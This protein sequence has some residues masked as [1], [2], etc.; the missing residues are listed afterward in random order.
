MITDD[1]L[2]DEWT[3]ASA[4]TEYDE[5][6]DREYE[7]RLYEHETGNATVSINEVQ[8][9]NEFEGWGYRVIGEVD[10]D[11]SGH[12]EKVGLYEDLDDAREGAR[13]YMR[14]YEG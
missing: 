9:P 2:P 3:A 11:D 13:E 10:A 7:S 8:E 14:D 5:L 4:R 12:E 6:M 1:N